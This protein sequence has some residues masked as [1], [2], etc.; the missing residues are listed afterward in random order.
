MNIGSIASI[1]YTARIDGL[2]PNVYGNRPIPQG[3]PP[4]QTPSYDAIPPTKMGSGECILRYQKVLLE[5]AA[6]DRA[7]NIAAVMAYAKG[8]TWQA[9]GQYIN[10][11]A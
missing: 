4:A 5:Y 2:W 6:A 3:I 9:T 10:V 1:G 7:D 8:N 11:T